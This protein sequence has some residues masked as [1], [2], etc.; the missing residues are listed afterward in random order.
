VRGLA[1]AWGSGDP[2]QVAYAAAILCHYVGDLNVPL[3]TTENYDG[4]LSGQKGVH[5]RWETGLVER[6]GDWQP[7]LRPATL[8]PRA[9]EAPWDWLRQSNALV[10]AL[11]RDDLASGWQGADPPAP[12]AGESEYWSEFNR[13]QGPSVREQLERAG[14]RTA[15]MILL[16]WHLAGE[17]A[18]SRLAGVTP[19]ALHRHPGAPGP[20]R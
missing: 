20:G 10:P 2:F 3:H 9:L 7:G 16:A 17:P 4:Q 8:D 14:L 18:P 15:Q 12:A 19:P 5:R 1:Q 13:R 6:L 11:L